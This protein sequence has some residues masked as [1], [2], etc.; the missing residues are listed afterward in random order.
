MD[1]NQLI[2][3]LLIFVILITW[4]TVFQ[5]KK[6][7]QARQQFLQDSIAQIQK[8]EDSVRAAEIAKLSELKQNETPVRSDSM[9]EIEFQQNFGSFAQLAKG[10]EKELILENNLIKIIFTNKGGKIKKVVLKNYNKLSK[11]SEGNQVSSPVELLEDLKNR[12]EYDIP[13]PGR[14]IKS[15]DL[16]FTDKSSSNSLEF[17]VNTAGVGFSQKYTLQPDSYHLDYILDWKGLS[18]GENSTINLNWDNYLDKIE[19]NTDFEKRYSTVYFRKNEGGDTDYCNCMKSAEEDLAS[20]KI[21]W[22][23]HS[24]QF[25]NMSL[26]AEDLPFKGGHMSTDMLEDDIEDLKLIRSDI[27]IP[28]E[29]GKGSFAMNWYIG[30]NEYKSLRAY[31]NDLE[32]IIPFGRSVFGTIN[33]QLIRPFFNFLSNYIG[34]IGIVIIV[35]IFIIKML[36]YPLTYKMLHSQARMGALKPELEQLKK[37]HKDEPQK[38]QMESMK[39]YREYGVSPLGGCMPMIVQMP[40][41]YA[42]FRF[43][44]ASITFRQESFLWATDLSS[45]DTIAHLPFEIPMFGSHISLFTVLW[46]ITTVIYT[47]YNTKHMDM[48][49]NPAMKYVQ[50]MMPLFFLVFFNNYASGLTCYM[51]FSNLFNISQTIL[52]KKFVFDEEKIRA[53]LEIKKQKPKKRGKFQSRLEEAMKQQQKIQ[54]DRKK[55]K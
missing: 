51:F 27:K 40:I 47:Y 21:D 50:Y 23:S 8:T 44:P 52:T 15:S 39:M 32:E 2:G 9:I 13:V 54:E 45:F 6:V 7:E 5:P 12:F 34:S 29:S 37:K 49:A 26:M 25:F 38:A 28:M 53:E 55:K 48:S 11:D 42:L 22:V 31:D 24:N 46:A 10:T 35:L 16:Y 3:F 30:P 36:L 17:A 41:W 18:P 43:F 19:E 1:R 33:R 14:T 20:N 4:S